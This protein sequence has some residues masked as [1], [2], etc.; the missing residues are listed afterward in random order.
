MNKKVYALFNC[1]EWKSKESYNLLAIFDNFDLLKKEIERMIKN[2]EAEKRTDYIKIK[3]M[4][5][6][7][8]SNM[9]NFIDVEI[10]NLNEVEK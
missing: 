7:N 10:F 2:G 5:L 4:E 6:I 8:I 3:D 9:V 1:D